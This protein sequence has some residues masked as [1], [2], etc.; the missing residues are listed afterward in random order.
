M[1]L[2]A[3]TA[4]LIASCALPAPGPTP[5]PDNSV[6]E[7]DPLP[8]QLPDTPELEPVAPV[9]SPIDEALSHMTLRE[10]LAGLLVVTV[11]G[12]DVSRQKAFLD[13]IP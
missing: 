11:S 3:I 2:A 4:A 9:L 8:L 10:K 7:L 6:I 5:A 13:D 1:P 12:M